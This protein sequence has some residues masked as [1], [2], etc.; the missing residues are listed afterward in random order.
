MI[1]FFFIVLVSIV[2]VCTAYLL[3]AALVW[4]ITT[5]LYLVFVWPIVLICKFIEWL[6]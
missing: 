1:T 5:G 6:L 3:I 4:V 2:A